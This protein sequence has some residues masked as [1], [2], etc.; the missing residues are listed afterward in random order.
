MSAPDKQIRS[1]SSYVQKDERPTHDHSWVGR[2]REKGYIAWVCH[3]VSSIELHVDPQYSCRVSR[4]SDYH[5]HV[6]TSM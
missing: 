2:I 4:V 1:E 5:D 3:G 6:P